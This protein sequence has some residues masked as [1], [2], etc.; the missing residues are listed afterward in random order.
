MAKEKRAK[1]NSEETENGG[2][3]QTATGK[4]KRGSSLGAQIKT[5][6]LE[7]IESAAS[8][9]GKIA[10]ELLEK[11]NSLASQIPTRSIGGMSLE[12]QLANVNHAINELYTNAVWHSEATPPYWENFDENQQ[13][14]LLNRKAR[15]EAAMKKTAQPAE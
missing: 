1:E 7:M 2:N 9:G 10:G 4:A 12:L 13:R 8:N 5:T 3:E 14:V 11:A 6:F 15:I